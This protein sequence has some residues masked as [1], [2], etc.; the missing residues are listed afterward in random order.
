[1]SEL[2]AEGAE[3]GIDNVEMKASTEHHETDNQSGSE[4]AP[5]SGE[6][7][8]QKITFTEE[9][10]KVVNDLAAKKTFKIREAEREA[11]ALRQQLAEAQA[12]VP[13][14]TRPEVPE[15]PDPYDDN[16][17]EVLAKREEAIRAAAKFDAAETVRQEQQQ[18][19][20]LQQQQEQQQVLVKTVTDYAK[21]AE[22]LGVNA[23]ELQV[24][25]NTVQQY[26]IDDQVV[27]HILNDEQGPLI[28]KYLS[29]NPQALETIRNADPMSAAVYISTEVK[30]KAAALGVKPPTA[31]D[32]VETLTGAGVAPGERG[33]KGATFE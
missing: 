6:S 19:Q 9:Q 17:Q 30:T 26:G 11:E 21:R 1:M 3:S 23:Q 5:D 32:P 20:V 8:E 4:S 33:P 31:P 10:Q 13:Q 22:T 29:Q 7:H 27:M 12:K 28:T 16:Y 24:A 14:E 18:A 2:Q 25:G 15:L